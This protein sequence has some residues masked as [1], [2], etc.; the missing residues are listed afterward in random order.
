MFLH[1]FLLTPAFAEKYELCEGFT[2]ETVPSN[3]AKLL[4]EN[5][6]I[7]DERNDFVKIEDLK[8][9]KLKYRDLNGEEKN[10]EMLINSEIA[11]EV[12]EIF[13]ELYDNNFPIAKMELIERDEY[14][15][16][17]EKSMSANNTSALRISE[18]VGARKTLARVW[19]G[20]R[21]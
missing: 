3:I 19:H 15:S 7:K 2:S 12:L 14:K 20:N 16:D 21:H 18:N 11:P 13:K 10:G 6:S 17:D 8:Y 9:L 1:C 4:M 5:S